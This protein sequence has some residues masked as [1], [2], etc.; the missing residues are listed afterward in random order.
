MLLLGYSWGEQQQTHTVGLESESPGFP[1][2][3]CSAT[4]LKVTIKHLPTLTFFS[5]EDIVQILYNFFRFL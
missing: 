4:V 2:G 3:I 1:A 5:Q